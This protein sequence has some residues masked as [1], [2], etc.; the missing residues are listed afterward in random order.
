MAS[1]SPKGQPLWGVDPRRLPSNNNK[2]FAYQAP[3]LN[4]ELPRSFSLF[5]LP[6]EN[7]A[8]NFSK[9][10]ESRIYRD[11]GQF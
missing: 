9:F 2:D 4:E 10:N 5:Y 1:P 11:F 6:K 3:Q 8:T 7:A